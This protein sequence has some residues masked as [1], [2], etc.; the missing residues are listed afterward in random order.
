MFKI[1]VT[2]GT[3]PISKAPY[4][5]V[6]VKLKELKLQLQ[7]LFEIGFIRKSDSP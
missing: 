7:D 4:R 2:P 5:M 6:P 3:T 1:D